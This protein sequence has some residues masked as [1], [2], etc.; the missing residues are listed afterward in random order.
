MH[1]DHGGTDARI[2][3]PSIEV[4]GTNAAPEWRPRHRGHT[5]SL[6]IRT[7][8]GLVLSGAAA[9]LVL[10]LAAIIYRGSRPAPHAA[11]AH[12][13]GAAHGM[14]G[15]SAGADGAVMLTPDQIRQFGVTFG[16]AEQR[17]LTS[18][19]RTVGIVT[20]DETRMTS[21][22]PRFSGFVERLHVNSTGQPVSKGQ[23]LAAIYSPDVLAAEQELLLARGLD[24][25]SSTSAVPGIPTNSTSL[26]SAARRRLQ[27]WGVTN[28]QID[29]VLRSGKPSPTVT[30][31]SPVSGVVTE[32]KVMQGQATQAGMPMYVITDLSRLWVDAEIRET[33]AALVHSGAPATLSFAAF[34]GRKY[35]GRISYVYPSVTTQ[36]RTVRARIVVENRDGVLRPGMYATVQVTA[37]VRSAL[38]VPSSAVV[39]T[40]NRSLVFVDAGGNRLVPHDVNVGSSFGDYTEIL[41]GVTPG[42]RVV[43][44]AQF[45]IDAES[46]VDEVMRSML[47]TEGVSDNGKR[48]G[49]DAAS[50]AGGMPDMPGMSAPTPERR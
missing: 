6:R 20:A 2:D 23:P 43:T 29:Q 14:V 16:T 40:G 44:S 30:L 31:Y 39:N 28:A 47:G 35:D 42:Q 46:N 12:P 26:V 22:T 49:A 7:R 18:D 50:H 24:Q 41:S 34:P 21:I 38:T 25:T 37:P 4:R 15:M 11:P 13:G 33:D 9:L 19:V 8:R 48:G 10:I 45:L 17:T 1:D 36:S 32:L 5:T 27:L 3:E